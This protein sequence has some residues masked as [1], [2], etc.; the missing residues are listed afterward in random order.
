MIEQPEWSWFEYFPSESLLAWPRSILWCLAPPCTV[1][2][3]ALCWPTY[4]SCPC[5]CPLCT[6]FLPYMYSSE[7]FEHPRF[8]SIRHHRR[9]IYVCQQCLFPQP[10]KVTSCQVIVEMSVGYSVTPSIPVYYTWSDFWNS[11]Q[12]CVLQSCCSFTAYR[13]LAFCCYACLHPRLSIRY[14]YL[15]TCVICSIIYL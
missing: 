8:R 6:I 9:R 7:R 12:P 3:C 5:V 15:S 2:P 14:A 4:L 1:P 11:A 10:G 13:W